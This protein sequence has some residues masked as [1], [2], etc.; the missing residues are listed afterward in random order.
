MDQETALKVA[1]AVQFAIKDLPYYVSIILKEN[2][3]RI[4]V[5][6][7]KGGNNAD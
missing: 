3:N 7:E 1:Q 4:V 5:I 6:R 2:G